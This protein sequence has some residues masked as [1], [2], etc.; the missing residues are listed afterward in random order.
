MH[1]CVDLVDAKLSNIKL[2]IDRFCKHFEASCAV[3]ES[4]RPYW[5]ASVRPN[6]VQR[7]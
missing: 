7:C 2:T 6:W 4:R 5:D 3:R 1:F